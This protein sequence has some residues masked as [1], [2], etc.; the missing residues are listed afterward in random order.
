MNWNKFLFAGYATIRMDFKGNIFFFRIIKQDGDYKLYE[1]STPDIADYLSSKESYEGM[2]TKD[3]VIK[4][5][6]KKLW[7]K[8]CR[9]LDI[10]I[11]CIFKNRSSFLDRIHVKMAHAGYCAKCNRILKTPEAI[12]HGIGN[13]C[14]KN[15]NIIPE[16]KFVY[17]GLTGN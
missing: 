2:L 12:Q 11:R 6:P 9:L 17:V 7:T 10:A 1:V 13:E 4:L 8:Q 15:L 16:E 3:G 5:L 14:F